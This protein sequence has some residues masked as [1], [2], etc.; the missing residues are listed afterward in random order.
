MYGWTSRRERKR[1]PICQVQFSNLLKHWK[2]T[3]KLYANKNLKVKFQRCNM[4][5]IER[6]IKCYKEICKNN[7]MHVNVMYI[8]SGMPFSQQSCP[9]NICKGTACWLCF[10]K[11]NST[12]ARIWTQDLAVWNTALWPLGYTLCGQHIVWKVGFIQKLSND[13]QVIVLK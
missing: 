10:R 7:T 5:R 13:F 9:L 2:R 11:S 3:L 6:F 1:V 12:L 8:S 4:L